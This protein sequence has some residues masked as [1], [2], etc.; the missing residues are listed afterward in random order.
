[1]ILKFDPYSNFKRVIVFYIL[2]GLLSTSTDSVIIPNIIVDL[3]LIFTLTLIFFNPN[4]LYLYKKF[5]KDYKLNYSLLFFIILFFLLRNFFLFNGD[6]L[7]RIIIGLREYLFPLLFVPVGYILYQKFDIDYLPNFEKFIKNIFLIIFFILILQV[8][9]KNY[10]QFDILEITFAKLGTIHSWYDNEV[11]LYSSVF[12]SNKKL[13][14]FIFFISILLFSIRTELGKTNYKYLILSYIIFFLSGSREIIVL[15]TIYIIFNY[16][17]LNNSLPKKFLI[18]LISIFF[19]FYVIYLSN[20]YLILDYSFS[21]SNLNSYY[22]RLY[23]IF[24]EKFWDYEIPLF[25][26]GLGSYGQI[27]KISLFYDNLHSQVNLTRG[28]RDS[29]IAKLLFEFGYASIFVIFFLII[30]SLK[31]FFIKI[32]NNFFK[33]LKFLIF[34][35][36]IL[37]IK[38]HPLFTDILIS[39]FIA[40]LVGVLFSMNLDKQN[41]D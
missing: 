30:F 27:S 6:Y 37:I 15:F 35:W 13:S 1:M 25:G 16:I 9:H 2:S 29:F 10:I 28:F 24:D 23:S 39:I 26:Y 12:S 40:I 22:D 21:I 18:I 20:Q 41:Y 34:C 17:Y 7:F 5:I 8:I 19:S 38:G 31:L 14:R 32:R 11:Y 4:Y 33:I 36:I 3:S